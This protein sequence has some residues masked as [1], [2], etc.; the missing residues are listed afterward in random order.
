MQGL[1]FWHEPRFCFFTNSICIVTSL[2]QIWAAIEFSPHLHL[3]KSPSSAK[4]SHANR[5]LDTP[6]ISDRNSQRAGAKSRPCQINK[7]GSYFNIPSLH[8]T[9]DIANSVIQLV[10]G[11]LLKVHE[12]INP[13]KTCILI[14]L[15]D[16]EEKKNNRT[17][18][19]AGKQLN[20]QLYI[21]TD[22][23]TTITLQLR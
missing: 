19:T 2:R 8:V 7:A 10:T 13:P 1:S 3:I 14:F 11:V 21:I 12:T 15:V 23:L 4:T 18:R 20:A 16:E 5:L 6:S 22:R 17:L 9:I